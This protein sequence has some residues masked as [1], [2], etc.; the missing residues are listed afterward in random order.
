MSKV[1]STKVNGVKRKAK[2]RYDR[3]VGATLV[4]GGLILGAM[5][6]LGGNVVVGA[7][8]ESEVI[9]KTIK[10]SAKVEGV[11]V[12]TVKADFNANTGEVSV[13][14]VMGTSY[15]DKWEAKDEGYK[16][17]NVIS[18][19]VAEKFN[20]VVVTC[21]FDI[22]VKVEMG[23]YSVVKAVTEFTLNNVGGYVATLDV[24]TFKGCVVE[25]IDW[26]VR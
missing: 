2:V 25:A 19:V 17:A 3:L 20:D 4:V 26:S 10:E 18:N 9:V 16:V 14:I 5:N 22:D 11:D 13:N 1:K 8:T 6:L 23:G 24:A 15:Y 12:D 21:N 7:V